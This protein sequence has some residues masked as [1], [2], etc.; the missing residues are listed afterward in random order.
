MMGYRRRNSTTG[1]YT[2]PQ[3]LPPRRPIPDIILPIQSPRGSRLS[4]ISTPRADSYSIQCLSAR[5]QPDLPEEGV[6]STSWG[7][8]A[9]LENLLTWRNQG[10]VERSEHSLKNSQSDVASSIFFSAIPDN[11]FDH[12]SDLLSAISCVHQNRTGVLCD[13]LIQRP[14]LVRLCDEKGNYL[15]HYAVSGD[16]LQMIDLLVSR[17]A[18]INQRNIQGYTPLHLAVMHS[19]LSALH[20]LITLGSNVELADEKGVQPMHLACE[21]N[22]TESL[23]KLLTSS[24]IDINAPGEFGSTVV[25]CCCRKNSVEC[26]DIVLQAGADIY[27]ADAVGYYAIHVAVFAG[28]SQCF[29]RLFHHESANGPTYGEVNLIYLTDSEGET[30]L[31][32]AVN[33]GNLEM[34]DFC[35]K[36]GASLEA[37]QTENLNAIHFACRRGDISVL[38]RL[39]EWQPEQT[40]R[41]LCA[42][43][44]RGYTPI[45]LA[46][47]FNHAEMTAILIQQRSPMELRDCTGCTPLLLAIKSCATA[48]AITLIKL[49]ADV[50]AFDGALRNILHLAI[51]SGALLDE[52][53]WEQLTKHGLFHLL[54][55]EKDEF[56]CTALHYATKGCRPN[57]TMSLVDLG[58]NCTAQNNERETPL[59]LAAHSGCLRTCESL[60]RTAHGLWAMN[61]PDARGR[62][63]LHIAALNGHARLVRLLI[64]KGSSFRRCQKGGT[65]LHLAAKTGC[66][67]TCR[68]IHEANSQIIDVKDFRGMTALH[69]AAKKNHSEVLEYLLQ[70]GAKI[71]PD[72]NGIYFVTMA[73]RKGNLKAAHVIAVS[74]RWDEIFDILSQTD[75]CPFEGF[76]REV[77]TLCSI[78]MDRYVTESGLPNTPSYEV[79]YDFKLLQPKADASDQALRSPLRKLLLMIEFGRNE[80]I[81]HPLCSAL[82]RCK[83]RHYGIW[84]HCASTAFYILFLACLSFMVLDH[85]PLRHA[86]EGKTT[87]DC[88]ALVYGS[89]DKLSLHSACGIIVTA[90]S[91]I[92]LLKEIMFIFKEGLQFYKRG[93]AIYSLAVYSVAIGFAVLNSTKEVNHHFVELSAVSAFLAWSYFVIHLMRFDTVGIFVVMFFQVAKTLGKSAIVVILVMISCAVPFYVLFRIPDAEDFFSLSQAEQVA[94]QDCFPPYHFLHLLKANNNNAQPISTTLQAF[95]NPQLTLLN[96]LSMSLGDFNFVDTIINPLTDDYKITLH[97]P[98]VTLIMF[99]VFLLCSPMILT[100]LLVGLA[101]GDIDNVRKEATIRLIA[102]IVN[103]YN[104]IER[105]VPRRLYTYLVV[106]TWKSNSKFKNMAQAYDTND[107]VYSSAQQTSSA[108]ETTGIYALEERIQI[109]FNELK[110]MIKPLENK[111]QRDVALEKN[112][113]KTYM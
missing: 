25:H 69:Y 17:G 58:A 90:I 33:C 82:L 76:I 38:T 64:T 77:P 21:L 99:I 66:L 80:L 98:E 15:I 73:L 78:A 31:H 75:Q 44:K 110:E 10:E 105:A 50:H 1:L 32:S 87:G 74:S 11:L 30:P 65:P 7:V 61:T 37:T 93:L 49:G 71:E 47:K 16:H 83:W 103:W 63:P 55:E 20:H 3:N 88:Y 46:A 109:Q 4:Q 106:H 39:L 112:S 14:D 70:M 13:M 60:L 95:Q 35:L 68:V 53:L 67:E 89:T 48:T 19:Q 97:F 59:H 26:L 108:K 92:Y 41:L 96:V 72:Y 102:Q 36:M 111:N 86:H 34:I 43:C 23:K 42:A 51:V 27:R 107:P 2:I 24:A 29:Q 104:S 84:L 62:L 28:S 8:A 18:D 22:D 40:G 45:H 9:A 85:E 54:V 81:I 6:D 56:G 100:N 79:N 57:L 94:L 101:V 52:K 5:F 91:G 12:Y 113:D